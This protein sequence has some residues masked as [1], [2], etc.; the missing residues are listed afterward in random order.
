MQIQT[1]KITEYFCE[2]QR[3]FD[4]LHCIWNNLQEDYAV[5][6]QYSELFLGIYIYI[7]IA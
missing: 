3:L 5:I 4:M 1:C 7:Y 2:G 6:M